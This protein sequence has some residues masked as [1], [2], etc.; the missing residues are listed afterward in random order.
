MLAAGI[1]F[2]LG[3]LIIYVEQETPTWFW[4]YANYHEKFKE[5][6]EEAGRGLIPFLGFLIDNVRHSQ[7]NI[8]P[9]TPL[10]PARILFGSGRVAYEAALFLCYLVPAALI[11]TALARKAWQ[12][13]WGKTPPLAIALY[14][15]FYIPYWA[16]TLRGHPDIVC[17][18][19]LGIATW[20][21][22]DTH[23]LLKSSLRQAIG[24]GLLLWVSFLLRRHLIFTVTAVLAATVV[25]GLA[26]SLSR[27]DRD[28]RQKCLIKLLKQTCATS[29]AA[30]APAMI[31]QH[32]YI[33]EVL[34]PSYAAS[35]GA[36]RQGFFSQVADAYALAG[37]LLLASIIAG[38][39]YAIS[40]RLP[41]IPFLLV[42]PLLSFL[43]FQLA[44]APSDHHLLPL[45]LF[46][47]PAACF[48][49]L[50]ISASRLEE[51]RRAGLALWLSLQ[52]FIFLH[53]FPLHGIALAS[54]PGLLTHLTPARRYPP[55]RL[56]SFDEVRRLANDLKQIERNGKSGSGFAIL[57]SSE[58]LNLHIVR[59]LSRKR[60]DELLVG[61]SEVDLRDAFQL[62]LL[63]ATYIVACMD[64]A[65][66]LGEENQRVVIVPSRALATPGNP[67]HE[68]YQRLPGHVYR[69]AD[70][71]TAF[72]YRRMK[73]KS[74]EEISWLHRELKR[75][76]PTW[77][78]HE[79]HIGKPRGGF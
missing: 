77:Q 37:P 32:D 52:G 55:M 18:I 41:G 8:T 5:I 53:T 65:I 29:T 54:A 74:P 43:G 64:P 60:I 49:F 34:Q 62:K 15:L 70:G 56:A 35:F 21:I 36:Y 25:F 12:S 9:I 79:T 76:H 30:L 75:F 28:G 47:F 57:A 72:I 66:H 67:L 39:A 42:V 23:Y 46:L 78:L 45:S 22:L 20:L 6:L 48:P 68:A 51:T 17:V 2:G 73:P 71:R 3:F 44:Q 19:P 26:S 11:S 4:D 16:P 61:V 10:L 50:L 58:Q 1:L 27:S 69:L 24:I 31:F 13:G 59:A 38:G 7:H 63:D 33:R 40:R 14:A